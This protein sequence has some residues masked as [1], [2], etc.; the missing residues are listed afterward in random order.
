MTPLEVDEVKTAVIEV[1]E[2]V[3]RV[4][5]LP[6]DSLITTYEQM[7]RSDAT[8]RAFVRLLQETKR[9]QLAVAH[10]AVK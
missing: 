7:S 8:Y 5:A 6:L 1:G 3:R 10:L 4:K 9:Y 2:V